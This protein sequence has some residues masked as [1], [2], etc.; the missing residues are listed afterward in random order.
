MEEKKLTWLEYVRKIRN[1]IT[2][3]PLVIC[4]LLPAIL[5]QVAMENLELEKVGKERNSHLDFRFKTNFLS[6]TVL[7][8]Q[9]EYGTRSL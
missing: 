5:N 4:W 3:E 9:L 1:F 8:C 7:P 2:I 6:L